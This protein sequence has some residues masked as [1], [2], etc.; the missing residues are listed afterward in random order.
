MHKPDNLCVAGTGGD[1]TI[2]AYAKH[3]TTFLID[4]K[5]HPDTAFIKFG[6]TKSPG[7][8]PG[9]YDTFYIGLAGEDHIHCS[10]LKCGNYFVYRTAWDSVANLRRY[11]GF[12][13]SIT[14]TS[15]EKVALV[16]VK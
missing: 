7:T 9:I 8:R 11:G 15:G 10:G 13:I 1:V 5:S 14:D 12:G 2:I 16:P 6:T 4:F 3:D